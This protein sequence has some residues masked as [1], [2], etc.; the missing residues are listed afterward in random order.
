MILKPWSSP[1]RA[2]YRLDVDLNRVLPSFFGMIGRPL[3]AGRPS[4]GKYKKELGCLRFRN[5]R[6]E[7][8]SHDFVGSWKNIYQRCGR[9]ICFRFSRGRG[10]W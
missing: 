9:K 8:E 3:N 5:E 7:Q 1:T 2:V 4:F 6:T 10:L